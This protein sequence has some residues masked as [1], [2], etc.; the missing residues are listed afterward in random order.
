[1]PPPAPSADG[2]GMGWGGWGDI[3]M[4]IDINLNT[5]IHIIID[6][7]FTQYW[8]PQAPLATFYTTNFDKIDMAFWEKKVPFSTWWLIAGQYLRVDQ[9]RDNSQANI[10]AL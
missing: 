3:N 8:Y 2:P 5:A 6:M 10:I 9:R 7:D 1:M 4:S